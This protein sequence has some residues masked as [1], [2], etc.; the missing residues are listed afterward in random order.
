MKA[1]LTD[2]DYL[3][4]MGGHFDDVINHPSSIKL[5]DDMSHVT[6]KLVFGMFDQVRLKPVFSTTEAS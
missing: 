1:R 6:R 3:Q 5:N 4:K 2:K